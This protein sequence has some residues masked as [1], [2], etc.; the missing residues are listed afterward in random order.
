MIYNTNGTRFRYDYAWENVK[1]APYDYEKHG[2]LKHLMS[3]RIVNTTNKPLRII[4]Q[5]F[6]TSLIFLMRYVDE[7]KNFKNPYWKNR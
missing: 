3:N 4:V 2:L 5:F 1:N 7:L 6:E